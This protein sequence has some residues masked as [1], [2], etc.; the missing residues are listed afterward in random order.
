M[1][2]VCVCAHARVCESGSKHH[3]DFE[4]NN[5]DSILLFVPAIQWNNA[6]NKK[7]GNY[8]LKNR[9]LGIHVDA[10][11]ATELTQTLLQTK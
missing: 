9:G 4:H 8:D 1:Q 3:V 5:N 11:W 6:G 7:S 2:R 10:L